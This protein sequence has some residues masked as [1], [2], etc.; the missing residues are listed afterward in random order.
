MTYSHEEMMK[1]YIDDCEEV[2]VAKVNREDLLQSIDCMSAEHLKLV[3]DYVM[4]LS[5]DQGL[6]IDA[7]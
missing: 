5:E 1:C 4:K 2:S 6:D 3:S 7:K